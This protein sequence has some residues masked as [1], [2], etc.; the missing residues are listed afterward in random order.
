MN[1]HPKNENVKLHPMVMHL[2]IFTIGISGSMLIYNNNTKVD[3]TYS[4]ILFF[5]GIFS[6]LSFYGFVSLL[7]DIKK[8]KN[9]KCFIENFIKKIDLIYNDNDDNND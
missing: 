9:I 4:F 8:Y 6:G 3:Y 2:L 7:A 1:L 5:Y